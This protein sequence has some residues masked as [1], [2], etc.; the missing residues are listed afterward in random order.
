MLL[1]YYYY[2]D[3]FG[4]TNTFNLILLNNSE[5]FTAPLIV[6]FSWMKMFLATKNE[7]MQTV[8]A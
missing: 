8:N 5:T 6:D 7:L 4:Y 1:L 3:I 2:Q